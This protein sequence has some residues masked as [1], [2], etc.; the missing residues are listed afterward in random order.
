MTQGDVLQTFMIGFGRSWSVEA[1]GCNPLVR[2]SDRIEGLALACGAAAGLEYGARRYLDRRRYI[3]WD[4]EI[5]ASRT[6][7]GQRNYH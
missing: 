7:D 4:R 2:L 1:W 6:N 5:E 3:E